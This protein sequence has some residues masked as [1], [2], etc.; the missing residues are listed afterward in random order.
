M[1]AYRIFVLVLIFSHSLAYP[2]QSSPEQ[3]LAQRKEMLKTIAQ[4][5]TE[6]LNQCGK[7]FPGNIMPPLTQ[8]FSEGCTKYVNGRLVALNI[9]Q[10][11]QHI[12]A[13]KQQT[14]PWN[15]SYLAPLAVCPE[16]KDPSSIHAYYDVQ[17]R[18][19]GALISMQRLHVSDSNKIHHI[20]EV[21]AKREY[22]CPSFFDCD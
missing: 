8:L 7:E 4:R 1:N 13:S 9:P 19:C 14:G 6:F 16:A 11:H 20:H 18:N 22:P 12:L 5:Y 3:L 10:L 15:V 17:T 21:C 2:M